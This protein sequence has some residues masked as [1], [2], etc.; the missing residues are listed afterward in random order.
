MSRNEAIRDVTRV[1]PET[2][3]SRVYRVKDCSPAHL[4]GSLALWQIK[5][6][7]PEMSSGVGD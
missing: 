4:T 7:L 2:W 5:G 1:T 6:Q 3:V